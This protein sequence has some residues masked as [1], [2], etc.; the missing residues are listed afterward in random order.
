MLLAKQIQH[1]ITTGEG[2]FN[3]LALAVFSH[4]YHHCQPYQNYC[5]QLNRT[6]ESVQS[7][8]QVPVV[9]TEVFRE[10][11]LCTLPVATAK[12]VFQT[13]GTSQEVKGKHYY[14]DMTLYDAAIQSSFMAGLNLS[15]EEK[16]IFRVLTPSFLDVPT[17]SLFYMFQRVVEWYGTEGSAFYFHNNEVDSERLTRDLLQDIEKNRPIV[18]LGTA[19]SFV[20]L[21]D[22]LQQNKITLKL[23]NESRL[24]ETGGLKGR[25]RTVSRDDL[26][27]LFRTQLGLPLTHCFSEYGMTE[28][29][30]QCYSK[31]NSHVFMSPHWMQTRIINPDS[32]EEA[33]VG[34]TGLVQFFDLANHTA[35]SA[36]TTSDLAIKHREGFELIGRAPKAVLR[37][38]STAFEI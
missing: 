25:V 26:Y 32:G 13:S 5:R 33:D 29:S 10:F 34:E 31:A 16:Q 35:V 19:F 27:A 38:C 6:P 1:Y 2:D 3:Q 28:L 37:G 14:H 24:L 21:C 20:N 36:I 23:P 4:Q 17:S 7:W 11:D 18:L 30:S 22:Y 15:A 12:Y 9:S 8:Q